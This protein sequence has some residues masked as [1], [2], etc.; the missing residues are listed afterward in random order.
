[1]TKLLAQVF[2]RL[3][4][5]PAAEQDAA[6]AILLAELESEERWSAAFADSQDAL[7][8]LADEA[9]RAFATGETTPLEFDKVG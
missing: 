6:A 9:R 8:E 4:K 5:L 1:M 2:D 3:S 7:S